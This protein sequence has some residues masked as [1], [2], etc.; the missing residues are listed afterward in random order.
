[1]ER[2]LRN[3]TALAFYLAGLTI[4]MLFLA[5]RFIRAQYYFFG[6]FHLLLDT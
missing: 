5:R 2:E 4:V 3:C 1:M 6:M